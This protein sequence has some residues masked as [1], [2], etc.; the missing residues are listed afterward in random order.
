MVCSESQI[1]QTSQPNR[2][3]KARMVYFQISTVAPYGLPF[4]V[5]LFS[6]ATYHRLCD[7]KESVLSHWFHVASWSSL[8]AIKRKLESKDSKLSYNGGLG[9]AVSP[10]AEEAPV[11][12][13]C[14]N[15]PFCLFRFAGVTVF[16]SSVS[17]NRPDSIT[18]SYRR[19][20][21]E[22][23]VSRTGRGSAF[24]MV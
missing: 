22:G 2:W 1:N 10:A 23:L 9:L 6:Y 3:N 11:S 15:L 16:S 21:A 18:S 17:S 19:F 5:H 20:F 4:D 24:T 13:S 7:V 8:V 12:E 14:P